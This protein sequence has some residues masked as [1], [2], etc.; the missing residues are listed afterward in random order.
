MLRFRNHSFCFT[1][2]LAELKRTQA[3]RQVRARGGL[4]QKVVNESLTYLV[5][6]SIP[7]IGWK[8]GNYGK[9]IEKA[10]ELIN[11]GAELQ[12]IMEA[13]FMEALEEVGETDSGA[14]DEKLVIIRYKML[15]TDGDI[16][17]E[18]LEEY[19]SILS[20][21]PACHVW[22]SVEDAQVYRYLQERYSDAELDA[23]YVFQC[24]IVKHVA[25]EFASQEFVDEVALGFESVPGVDGDLRWYEKKEGTATF[26]KLLQ[27]VPI[28]TDLTGR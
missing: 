21:S 11:R 23:P 8:H 24:R 16:D 4:T 22:A 12:I 14:I 17:L 20:E 1:G 25:L 7:A 9:K 15:F 13:D 2:K 10:R 28:R 18:E 19:L 3:E 27:E 26:A 6:G 5:I